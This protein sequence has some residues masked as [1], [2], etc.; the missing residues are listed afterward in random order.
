MSVNLVISNQS[1]QNEIAQMRADLTVLAAELRTQ[2]AELATL[3]AELRTFESRY[4]NV[5]GNRYDELAEIEKQ[6]AQLQ[7]LDPDEA[8][9]TA[10]S[11]ADDAVG[12]GQNRFHS[13]KLR[14]L[15]REVCRRF[16]PDLSADEQE[17]EHRHQLMIEINQAYKTGAEDR[18]TALLEAGA[19]VATEGSGESRTEQLVLVRRL[20]EMKARLLAVEQEIAEITAS[21]TWRLKLRVSQAEASGVDLLADL[22]AQVERQITKA[23]N[24]REAV[25]SVML[26]A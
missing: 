14:R 9:Q 4:L 19:A 3:Q 5:V 13:D 8:E 6:I 26:G 15:Y 1:G 20:A 16:H 7:G 11:L 18:L 2:E 24:R 21:E 10:D 22:V 23:R 25:Q 17:R 12:C